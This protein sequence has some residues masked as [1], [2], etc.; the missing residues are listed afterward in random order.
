[1]F[2]KQNRRGGRSAPTLGWR[3]SVV[4]AVALAWGAD[5][6]AARALNAPSA[7]D[8]PVVGAAEAEAVSDEAEIS[9]RPIL[10]MTV[11]GQGPFRFIVD[12]GAN[13]TSVSPRL[14]ARLGLDVS[15]VVDVNGVTGRAEANAVTLD[16]L[17]FGDFV[18]VGVEAPV[19]ADFVFAGTDGIVGVDV[20]EGK[21]VDFNFKRGEVR[22]RPSRS[23]R[24]TS[25]RLWRLSGG[26]DARGLTSVVANIGG[27]QADVLIDTGAQHTLANA[28]LRRDIAERRWRRWTRVEAQVTGATEHVMMS[29]I[30]IVPSMRIGAVRVRNVPVAFG[31]FHVFELWELGERPALLLGSDVLSHAE[32]LI[33]DYATGEVY[34]DLNQ[35]GVGV[36]VSSGNSSLLQRRMDGN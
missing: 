5:G 34:L 6:A 36:S 29:E 26:V 23:R 27:V 12:T 8:A 15:S 4:L 18:A 22:I 24:V 13:R 16:R 21:R 7:I 28:A 14:V 17:Q 3:A 25:A 35:R 19:L 11:N 32:R 30:A 9:G 33:I 20:L 31:D 2:L 1:M 10:R